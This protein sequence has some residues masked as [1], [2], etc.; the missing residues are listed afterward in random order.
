ML[1]EMISRD[2]K[3]QRRS[4][5]QEIA[6]KQKEEEPQMNAELDLNKDTTEP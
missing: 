5:K 2:Y 6:E 3:H 4:N 1:N